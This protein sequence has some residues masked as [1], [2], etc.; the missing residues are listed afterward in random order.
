MKYVFTIKSLH[1]Y[2]SVATVLCLLLVSSAFSQ[3]DA[4][5]LK[6][7][8]KTIEFR[9]GQELKYHVSYGFFFL[10]NIIMQH[11]GKTVVNNRQANHIRVI[12]QS[13][14]LLFW[15]AHESVYDSFISD[16]M[17]VIRFISD[18]KIDGRAFNGF[19]D[20]DYNR[21]VIDLTLKDKKKESEPIKKTIPL[22]P[23]MMD[24]ISLIS[25]ART[26]VSNPGPDTVFTFIEDNYGNVVFDFSQERELLKTDAI[27]NG[28]NTVHFTGELKVK[29]IA[30]VS[31][32]FE[33][34]FSDDA[35]KIPI[36]SYM[37]VVFGSVKLELES[38]KKWSPEESKF[39]E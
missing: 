31:G 29:G 33:S 21:K 6:P 36:T 34:W 3:K 8:Q 12:I 20:F 19:Y 35:S 28:V 5:T 30:G 22:Q 18:E 2:L 32:P 24:G 1:K 23:R 37:E 25:Y 7:T 4:S 15:I 38:W 27:P 39:K 26:N 17:Q 10:G 11:K 14:P 9:E 13:N 16:S